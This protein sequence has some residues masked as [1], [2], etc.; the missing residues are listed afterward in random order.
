MR[1][2][3]VR[4]G[5]HHRIRLGGFATGLFL[6]I[7]PSAAACVVQAQT[8]VSGQVLCTIQ[9]HRQV[10]FARLEV[11]FDGF[12]DDSRVDMALSLDGADVRCGPED[13]AELSGESGEEGEVTLFCRLRVAPSEGRTVALAAQLRFHHAEFTSIRL[14]QEPSQDP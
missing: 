12:H 5:L 10:S 1:A 2:D 8:D 4:R 13:R 3:N 14:V 11:R 6:A 7:G 9:G